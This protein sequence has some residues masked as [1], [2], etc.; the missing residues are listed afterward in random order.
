MP[1]LFSILLLVILMGLLYWIITV[2]PIPD[3][4]KTIALVI[5]LVICLVYLLSMLFGM[6]APFPVFRG[7]Y[8]Y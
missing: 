6:A 7:G 2:L 8:R 3:P 5:V 4:F 1:F